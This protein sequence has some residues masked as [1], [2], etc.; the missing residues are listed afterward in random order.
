MSIVR[1]ERIARSL[2]LEGMV[3]LIYLA[4]LRRGVY[5]IQSMGAFSGVLHSHE[6]RKAH[7]GH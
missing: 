7:T 5:P 1:K 2:N 3:E 4:P 6:Q